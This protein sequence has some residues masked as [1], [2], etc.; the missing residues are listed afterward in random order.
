MRS[1]GKDG[2]GAQGRESEA[3]TG[4]AGAMSPDPAPHLPARA[5]GHRGLGLTKGSIAPVPAA[6]NSFS[7][8]FP[9]A[10]LDSFSSSPSHL[11]SLYFTPD[12]HKPT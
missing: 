8:V 10:T 9:T 1:S 4:G 11:I 2:G 7:P 3:P 5:A 6:Q 12:C